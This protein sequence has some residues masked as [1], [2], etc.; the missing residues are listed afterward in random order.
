[1]KKVLSVFL[2]LVMMFSIIGAVDLTV[3]AENGI[4]SRPALSEASAMDFLQFLYN[5]ELD[6]SKIR[7]SKYFPLLTGKFT[8]TDDEYEAESIAFSIFVRT[9]IN[10]LVENSEYNLSSSYDYL[11]SYLSSKLES[12][13]D[14]QQEIIDE[15][16]GTAMKKVEE[17]ILDLLVN[18]VAD[19]TDIIVTEEHI[20]WVNAIND[21]VGK[22]N[23]LS[24]QVAKYIEYTVAAIQ[25]CRFVLA[26]EQQQRY[27]YFSAYLNNRDGYSSSSDEV[28]KALD[29]C[30]FEICATN[31]TG[32]FL[33]DSLSWITKKDSWVNHRETIQEWAEF[34]YQIENLITNETI[35]SKPIEYNGHMYQIIDK[36]MNWK[37]AKAYCEYLGGHLVT[38]T[39]I[40]EQNFIYDNLVKPTGIGF[41]IG[42]TDEKKEGV[43][44]WITGEPYDYSN[45]DPGEPNN[46]FGNENY[47]LIKST[48]KWND[49]HLERENW[50]FI[51][52]WDNTYSNIIANNHENESHTHI[53]K[54]ETVESTCLNDGYT[55]Y[56]CET[57]HYF[58]IGNYTSA[59]GHDYK[60]SRIAN[61]TCTEKGYDLYTCSRCNGTERRNTVTALGHNYSF[62]KTVAPNCSAQ[63]YDLYTCSRCNGTEKRNYV[64]ALGHQYVLSNHS[65]PTCNTAG[66][67]EYKCSVCQSTKKDEIAVLDGSALTSALTKAQTY[68]MK[69]YFTQESMAELQTV[70]SSHKDDLDRLTTQE[71]VDGAVTE[72]NNAISNLVLGDFAS[73]VT[74]DGFQWSWEKTTGR[75]TV[76]GSGNMAN[77]GTATMPW[78]DV[79]PYTTEIVLFEGITSIGNYAFYKAGSVEK[80]YFPST[81]TS[82]GMRA[83]EFCTSVE[84]LVIPDAVTSIGY[85]TFASMTSLRKVTVPASTTYRSYCFDQDRAIEEIIITYG[86]DGIMPDAKV[87][88][89]Q[90]IFIDL[91]QKKTGAFGPWRYARNAKVI[92]EDGVTA[93]GNKAFY[94]GTG[95]TSIRIPETVA[96]IGEN[97]FQNCTSLN[98]ISLSENVTN[99]GTGAFDNCDKLKVY[100]YSGSYTQTYA[101]EN[102][103][104]FA[105]LGDADADG[106]INSNDYA[107]I[108]SCVMCQS[109]LNEEQYIT[110]DY[111]RDGA[112][113]AFDVIALDVYLHSQR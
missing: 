21:G 89:E 14:L 83:F 12:S 50:Y 47:A 24:D 33:I 46:E 60:F 73:G 102:G 85:G 78:Y 51:C 72:I 32:S 7:N 26:K 84:E 10:E 75:L 87:T 3:A 67:D 63:G 55:K 57:C 99:I 112:V 15:L 11:Y 80:I 39:T 54:T 20:S 97:A 41:L 29:D 66:Y 100:G 105:F 49:G 59:L 56:V 62:T 109:L 5:E 13:K 1:M 30:N 6:E 65:A 77:Y 28:F 58:Y 68:L 18:C 93:I 40:N 81:L 71:A 45:W 79:L 23:N 107:M 44:E 19:T 113:D 17:G 48:G 94:Q 110:A 27:W 34:V 111:N 86:T 42:L 74:D 98:T 82:I 91:L 92:I 8:G 36:C 64:N 4:Y 38:I 88:A 2:S 108:R 104:T 16:K 103:I 37:D 96:T 90:S 70:Y 9:R 101:E 35:S 76:T 61:P 95:I 22:I 31:S 43:F 25:G 52:E 53:F 69:D 106:T